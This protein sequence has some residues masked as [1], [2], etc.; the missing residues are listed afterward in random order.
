MLKIDGGGESR[1]IGASVLFLDFVEQRVDKFL[2]S[3]LLLHLIAH[4]LLGD[5]E[6]EGGDFVAKLLLSSFA[7]LFD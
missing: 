4:H 2:L 5:V 3:F 6:S 7:L 1:G